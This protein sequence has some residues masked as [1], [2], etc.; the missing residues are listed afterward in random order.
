MVLYKPLNRH[1]T[2]LAKVVQSRLTLVTCLVP[3]SSMLKI[4]THT[5]S[6]SPSSY[7]LNPAEERAKYAYEGDTDKVMTVMRLEDEKGTELGAIAWFAVH[8]VSMSNTNLLISGDNKGYA[9]YLWE[10][11]QNK[12]ALPG[13]GQFVAAFGQTN[14][15]DVSP[16]TRGTRY[17][18][19]VSYTSIAVPMA[20]LVLL[21]RYNANN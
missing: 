14:E 17:C 20:V 15:G 16:N 13:R 12:G 21:I 10:K 19:Y 18:T 7:L 11:Y 8:C 2:I 3:I 1:T 6:R 5:C 4:V 9:S